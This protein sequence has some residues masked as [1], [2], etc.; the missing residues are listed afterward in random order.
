MMDLNAGW[1]YIYG[2]P[3]EASSHKGQRSPTRLRMILRIMQN[4]NC[5]STFDA[6]FEF[7][8]TQIEY[9]FLPQHK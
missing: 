6:R 9:H 5:Y 3:W 1:P 8:N 4:L 7:F 2:S